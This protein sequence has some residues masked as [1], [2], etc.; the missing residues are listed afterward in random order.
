MFNV[1]ALIAGVLFMLLFLSPETRALV[2]TKLNRPPD[3]EP[4]L[5]RAASMISFAL[6][7]LC[8]VVAIGFGLGTL[9][10]LAVLLFAR[11][12]S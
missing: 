2:L 11:R 1:I 9:A 4:Q 8:F 7:Y 6:F 3:K 10:G 5:A 12:P